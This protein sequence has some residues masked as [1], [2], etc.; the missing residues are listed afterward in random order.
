MNCALEHS[1]NSL[2][3]ALPEGR[4]ELPGF[5]YSQVHIVRYTRLTQLE[6]YIGLDEAEEA[7]SLIHEEDNLDWLVVVR[8]K[9][10]VKVLTGRVEYTEDTAY[11]AG[12]IL[13][14]GEPA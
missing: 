5:Y 10:V 1:P 11:L 14:T 9:V 6:E 3:K 12:S 8:T 2:D 7:R 4:V 13:V